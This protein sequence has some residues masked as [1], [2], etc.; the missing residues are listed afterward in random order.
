MRIPGCFKKPLALA[1]VVVFLAGQM[2]FAEAKLDCSPTV[3]TS[4]DLPR[5]VAIASNLPGTG[6]H[7][8]ARPG[9]GGEQSYADRREST[10][11][12]RPQRLDATPGKRRDRVRHHQH[13]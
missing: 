4:N 9:R 13:S 6:A 5:T 1:A 2:Q 8:M 7:A 11:L 12:Q 10:A 3:N